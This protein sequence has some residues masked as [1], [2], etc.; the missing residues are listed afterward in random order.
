MNLVDLH[1]RL[2][3]IIPVIQYIIFTE[4]LSVI[5]LNLFILKQLKSRIFDLKSLALDI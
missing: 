2:H 1:L 3:N 5:P 4:C